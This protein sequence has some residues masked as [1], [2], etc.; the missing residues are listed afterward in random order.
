MKIL[1]RDLKA[2]ATVRAVLAT[3]LRVRLLLVLVLIAAVGIGVAAVVTYTEQRSFLLARADDQAAA[4]EPAVSRVLQ[5]DGDDV[6]GSP[7]SASGFD[8]PHVPLGSAPAEAFGQRRASNGKPVGAGVSIS[9]PGQTKLPAPILPARIAVGQ[10]LTVSAVG[11][12]GLHYRVLAFSNIDQ[13]GSTVVAVPLTDVS[14]SLQRLM[15]VEVLVGCALLL[16]LALLSWWLVGLG[17]RPLERMEE[18]AEAI[19]A[20]DLSR[21]VS[22]ASPESEVG[23]LGLAL[24]AM[25]A[26]IEEAFRQRQISESRLKSFLTDASHELRTPLTAI[27][28]YAE[29]LRAK[30]VSNP[31]QIADAVA[32]IEEQAERMGV[33]VG[34]LLE[35]ARLDEKGEVAPQEVELGAL[36]E[37]AVASARVSA[38]ASTISLSGEKGKGLKVLGDRAQLERVFDNLLANTRVHTPEGTAVEVALAR[39]NE[40]VLVEVRD[41]GPGLPTD[42]PAAIFARFWRGQKGRAPG[43]AG[44]GLGL[45][46]VAAIIAVHGGTVIA[47]NADGGGASFV[48]RLPANN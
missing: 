1:G 47:T 19:A 23:R 48:V 33:L 6:P 37:A 5:Q 8:R 41:H 14:Q 20:G 32:R 10:P 28:G 36:V 16:V 26:Q 13:P 9:L 31:D 46:I 45:S 2:L 11:D 27:R 4:V 18:T 35:I 12:S 24:N 40:F 21:R 7:V 43:P 30:K 15:L 3:S 38:S 34:D 22:P 29:L 44:A 25:L 42:D 17:L 39:E